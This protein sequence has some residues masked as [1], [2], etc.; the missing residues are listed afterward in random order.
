MQFEHLVEVNDPETP[1][2]PDL[3]A[4]EVWFGLL[5]RA[6]NP[7]PFLPGLETCEILSREENQLTRRLDFGQVNVHDTVVWQAMEWIRFES[8][9]TETH[10]GGTLTI[11]IEQPVAASAALFLRFTYC[12]GLHEEEGGEVRYTEYVRSAYHASDLDTVR[13]IRMIAAST[14]TE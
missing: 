6:E 12:T 14:R 8:A 1:E 10:P 5:C 2:I 11:R 7:R 9:A 3:Q 13:V 4:E